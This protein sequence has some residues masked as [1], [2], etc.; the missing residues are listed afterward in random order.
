MK[1]AIAR[2]C[3][4]MKPIFFGNVAQQLYGVYHPARGGNRRHTGV[5]LCY[6]HVTEYNFVHRAY[7]QLSLQLSSEGFDVLRFD[8]FGT[9]D[10]AGETDDGSVEQWLADIK[11][12]AEELRDI[13]RVTHLSLVGKQLGGI[14]AVRAALPELRIRDLVLWDPILKGSDF[15]ADLEEAH[16]RH[17]LAR[18]QSSS[19]GEATGNELLGFP[20]PQSLRREISQLQLFEQHPIAER[21]HLILSM[22]QATI[23][24]MNQIRRWSGGLGFQVRFIEI[25]PPAEPGPNLARESIILAPQ[26]LNRIFGAITSQGSSE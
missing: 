12:A 24:Q 26:A 22:S 11:T 8:Y 15:I 2:Q 14:L 4:N 20:F 17:C 10:S 16:D 3:V 18:L 23:E 21:M 1:V 9:G 6:P 13:A 25:D 19:D 5:L 7:R